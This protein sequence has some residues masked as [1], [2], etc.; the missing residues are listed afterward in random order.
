[1]RVYTDGIPLDLAS[2]LLPGSSRLNFGLLTHIHLHAIAQ[3]KYAGKTITVRPNHPNVSRIAMLGLIDN[4]ERTIKRFQWKVARTAWG[5]Y[6]AETNLSTQATRHKLAHVK[7]FVS[8]TMA[9]FIWDIGANTGPYDRANNGKDK[10]IVRFDYDPWAVEQNYLKTKGKKE[11]NIFP[12]ILDIT[13]PSSSS[14]WA[15]KERLSLLERGPCELVIALALV[16]HLAIA[17]NLPLVNI[18]NFFSK[19][20][21]W[22][23]IEF[24]PKSDSQVKKLLASREDIFIDYDLKGFI[25]AFQETYI[26]ISQAQIND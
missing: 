12:L 9:R 3:R 6:Y 7:K 5:E 25:N 26:T 1:M 23:I 15:N 10:F 18:A 21:K 14:G 24:I 19:L 13:N 17:N 22:L 16:Q 8:Q 11:Q 20:G 2:S 4:L